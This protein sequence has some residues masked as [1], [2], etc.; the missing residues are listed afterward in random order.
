MPC[1]VRWPYSQICRGPKHV[2]FVLHS[3]SASQTNTTT[4]CAGAAAAWGLFLSLPGLR[5]E[6]VMLCLLNY[7]CHYPQHRTHQSQDYPQHAPDFVSE[8]QTYQFFPI[9]AQPSLPCFRFKYS[10]VAWHGSAEL[11]PQDSKFKAILGYMMTNKQTNLYNIQQ[12]F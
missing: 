4:T 3:R 2:Y 6:L 8:A 7:T 9:M 5:K 10:S 12:S 11:Q 1:V